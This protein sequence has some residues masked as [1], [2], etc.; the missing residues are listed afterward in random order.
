MS[1]G[2]PAGGR[3]LHTGGLADGAKAAVIDMSALHRDMLTAFAEGC[4]TGIPVELLDGHRAARTLDRIVVVNHHKARMDLLTGKLSDA[5]RLAARARRLAV[6]ETDDEVADGFREDARRHTKTATR[7]QDEIDRLCHEVEGSAVP[8][9]FEGEVA[10]LLH[11]LSALFTP[12]D[13]RVEAEKAAALRTVLHQPA[14]WRDG[15]TVHWRAGLL[16]PADGRVYVLGPFTGSVPAK[17]RKLTPAETAELA[18]SG[19]AA[20]R[21]R[22]T[23]HQLITAGYPMHLARCA[24]LAPG[25]QL[26]RVLLGENVTWPD[27]PANFDHTKFNDHV[28]AIWTT[29]PRWAKGVY[30]HTNPSRQALADIVAALGGFASVPQIDPILLTMGIR[31]NAVYYMTKPRPMRNPTVPIWPATLTRLG[32]WSR[33][34]G[35][36]PNLMASILCPTCGRPATAVVR[37]PE[38]PDALLCRTCA[39]MPSRPDL[40]FPPSYLDLALPPTR[41]DPAPLAAARVAVDRSHADATSA[42]LGT[43]ARRR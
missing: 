19:G 2:V 43:R 16:V 15:D 32:T 30:C 3:A 9:A 34:R 25:G 6:E 31:R 8:D 21:R 35:A 14:L 18:G 39:I 12:K 22:S 7:L 20:H 24:S 41:L 29:H 11:G 33:R 10:Y 40:E 23:M 28:R 26:P 4:R 27:C 37:V 36:P 5:R 38:L 42:L 13:G 1:R 17:G